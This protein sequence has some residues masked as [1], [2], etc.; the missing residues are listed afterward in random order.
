MPLPFALNHINLWALEDEGG[1]TL[2]DTGIA[3]D[4]TRGLWEQLFAGPLAGRK[5]VRLIVTHFHPDHAGLAGWLTERFGV[6]LW[7]TRAE[8]LYARMLKQDVGPEMLE[9]QVEFYE[10]A[11]APAEYLD[12]VRK[13]GPTYSTRVSQIPRAYR[14]MRGGDEIKI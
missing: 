13:V 10:K 11:G 14:R 3:D 12:G 1:R 5:V 9:Q 8:W 6:D 4:T 2:V 7:M